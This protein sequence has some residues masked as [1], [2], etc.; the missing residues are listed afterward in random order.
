MRTRLLLTITAASAAAALVLV[1]ADPVDAVSTRSFLLDD[2]A[3]LAAGELDATAV[4]S[5]GSVTTGAQVTRVELP[6]VPVAYSFARGRDGLFVGT[7]NDGKIYRVRGETVEPFAETGQLLV[8]A[9]AFAHGGA[10]YAGTLPEGRIYRVSATGEVTEVVRPEEAEHV[11]ALVY[12]PRRRTLFAATGPEGKVYAINAAGQAT[13]YY[14]SDAGHVMSLALDTDGTLYA[15]TSDDALV[16]RLERP[17]RAEVVHDF[18]GN[19]ITAIAARGG[20]LA[21]AANEFPD[22]PRVS[23]STKTSSTSRP[24]RPGT[25]KGRL[26]RVGSDG[27]AERVFSTDDGHFTSVQLAEDGTLFAGAGKEGRIY[28]VGP[29]RASATWIDVDERQVL[30]I[31]LLADEPVFITGD[32]AA[33]Y[34]VGR[35]RP[36]GAI[37]TSKVLDAGFQARWGQL[38]WRGSGTLRLQTRS[39]NTEEPD[40]TWSEWSAAITTPGPVRSAGARFVQIRASFDRDPAA[41]IRAVQL[42]YLP[43]NQRA[44]VRGVMIKPPS[45]SKSKGKS[46]DELPSPSS[47]YPLTWKVDNPDEDTLRFRL[48]YRAEDQQ[49]WRPMFREDTTLTEEDYTWET[50]A[51]PDGWYVVQVEASDELGNPEDSTLRGTAESEPLLIDNHAPDIEGLRFQ[52]GRLSGR[53]RDSV[54]P[55]ARLEYSVDAGDFR[56]FFPLDGLLDTADERFEITPTGLDPGQHI[57]AVRVTDAGGNQRSAE[58]VVRAR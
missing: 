41:V 58:L 47:R 46:P 38:T 53:A 23:G 13:V 16:L 56:V 43:Q 36:T 20:N 27:R 21:V 57:L 48:R 5:N 10:L 37:W 7:G 6:D 18:P 26:W 51:I 8:S 25:G 2:A 30:A 31:D 22:P 45:A 19:E 39:G 12:D 34:H 52:G 32:G 1:A 29:N 44:V 50:Q 14:D 3:S 15:G 4:H 33:V 54:G 40:E 17:G 49:Q 11:W 55:I 28:R 35:G 24:A 9:L 42:F